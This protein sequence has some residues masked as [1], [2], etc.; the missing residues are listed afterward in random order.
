LTL[1]KWLAGFL[2]T[3][4]LLV[5]VAV[6]VIPMV[7]DPNDYREDLAAL[8]KDNTG[9]DLDLQGDLKISVFPWLGVRTQGLRFSQPAGIDGDMVSVETAQLRIKLMPLLSKKIEVDTIVLDAP[10]IKLVTLNDGTDSFAGLVGETDE[11]EQ[12]VESTDPSAAVALAIQGLELSNG[13]VTIDDRS[14]GS[15]TELSEL[16]VTTGNLIGDSLADIDASGIMTSNDGSDPVKFTLSGEAM[17]DVDTTDV[18]VADLTADVVQGSNEIS[19]GF[20]SLDFIGNSNIDLSGL[21]VSL[22]GPAEA[23]VTADKVTANLDSQQA[24]IPLLSI[25][26]GELQ[27]TLSN[28]K[29]TKFIDAPALSGELNV[30]DFNAARL[31][32]DFEIDYQTTDSNALENVSLQAQFKGSLD[33]AEVR[34]LVLNLDESKLSGNVA[35]S[36]FEKPSAKFDLALTSLDLDRYL[37]PSEEDEASDEEPVSGG[38]ALAVP[39]AVFKEINANGD[40]KAQKFVAGGVEMNNIDVAV[41]SGDGQVTITPKA[42][43][44]DGSLAGKIEYSEQAE[45]SKLKVNNEVSLVQLGQLLNAADVTDQLS[46]LGTVLVDLVITEANGIQSNQGVITLNAKDGAIQGVDVKNVVDGAY[47]YYQK[48]KGVEASNEG[49]ASEGKSSSNDETKFAELFGTF[50]LN[51]NV[52]TNND[53]SMKAPLF[54]VAGEGVIDIA[55]QTLDYVVD[56]KLVASTDGQGGESRDKLRGIPIPIRFSGDLTAPNYSIDIKRM[57]K[58]LFEKDVKSKKAEL[59]QEKL[60]I[61]GGEE[62]STKDVFKGFLSKKLDEEVNGDQPRERP[63]SDTRASE[64]QSAGKERPIKDVQAQPDEEQEPEDERSEKDK[65]KEDLGKKLLDSIF[66]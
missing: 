65:L 27:G 18:Q 4:V 57:A 25:D 28:L 20:S 13:R 5:L 24:E 50:K 9:R 44:Y 21:A 49:Q 3:L 58:A 19:L 51:D 35:V 29:V 60:G 42:Q 48:F 55:K 14:A 41:R 23:S 61:E 2:L 7:V 11:S 16:N 39:M 33:G 17:I 59:I 66:D 6:I 54:R 26:A 38:E 64:D 32:K 43:L 15:I 56:V 12:T 22:R 46:G 40:F 45:Q 63:L 8:V 47:N 37:P 36:N 52:I 62:L 53:F 1:L 34:E 10:V 30:P 31:L